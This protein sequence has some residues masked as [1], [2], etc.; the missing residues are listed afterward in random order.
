[1]VDRRA[2]LSDATPAV[3]LLVDLVL[4]PVQPAVADLRT[5]VDVLRLM[6]QARRIRGGPPD[7]AMF[8]NRATKGTRL[9]TEAPR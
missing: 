7:A 5:A 3:M 4:T 1:M 6:G 8:L 9:L 2:G